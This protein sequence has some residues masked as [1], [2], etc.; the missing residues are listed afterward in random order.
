MSG[1]LA[2]G[3]DLSH[4]LK[5]EDDPTAIESMI[6]AYTLSVAEYAHNLPFLQG[7][8]ELTSAIGGFNNT[9]EDLGQR[10]I[11]F[12]VSKGTDIF[13]GTAGATDR[14]TF[15]LLSY[16]A[17]TTDIPFMGSDSFLATMEKVN[18]PEASNTMPTQKQLEGNA[19]MSPTTKPSMKRL[20]YYKSKN[21]Y[22]SNRLPPK[23]NFWG[24]R[25]YQTEGRFDEFINPVRVKSSQYTTLDKE[26]I[27]L[28]ERT[29]EIISAHPRK[30]GKSTTDRFQ[31]SG[32]EYNELVMLTNEIDENGL[33]PGDDGYDLSSFVAPFPDRACRE[34]RIQFIGV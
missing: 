17:S 9:T 24:E 7:I 27:R 30:I 14:A 11:N 28:S 6:K 19:L 29:D 12:G 31:L 22:F 8:S 21:S 5:H 10:L 32:L 25:L 2:M 3:A 18:N 15:G 34:R 13:A 33:L 1:L 26:L 16:L 23:L 4:Y 20:N